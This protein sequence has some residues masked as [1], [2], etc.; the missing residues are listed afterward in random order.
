VHSLK[1]LSEFIQITEEG[2][3]VEVP[4]GNYNILVDMMA[5]LKA[6]KERQATTDVMFDPLKETI[7]LLASYNQ[8][9]PEDVHQ[10]LEVY[11][12]TAESVGNW[13]VRELK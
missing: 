12:Y 1:D 13:R 8:E 5:N 10:Q 4:E 6:V 3:G 2:L 9:M 7:E 11:S